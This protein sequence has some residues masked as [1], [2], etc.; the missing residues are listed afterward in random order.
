MSWFSSQSSFS[1]KANGISYCQLKVSFPFSLNLSHILY[2]LTQPIYGWNIFW[3]RS[4][5]EVIMLLS[6]W[7]TCCIVKLW[8][9]SFKFIL[10]FISKVLRNNINLYYSLFIAI[11]LIDWTLPSVIKTFK[12]YE[13]V[14][15]S[16]IVFFFFFE[17]SGL[18]SLTKEYLQ[19]VS[20]L[21]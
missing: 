14:Y 11:F 8:F 20:T 21:N 7:L 2:S 9:P 13:L 19:L 4:L 3:E 5:I 12:V 16:F 15:F 10:S 1:I 6:R 18:L 17:R